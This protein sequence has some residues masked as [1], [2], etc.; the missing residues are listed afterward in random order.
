MGPIALV[1]TIAAVA[2][3]TTTSHPSRNCCSILEKCKSANERAQTI[4]TRGSLKVTSD[5]PL[6]VIVTV[7]PAPG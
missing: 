5:T 4:D 7:L 1:A 3:K 6:K 2:R